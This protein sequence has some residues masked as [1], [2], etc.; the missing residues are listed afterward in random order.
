ME[1]IF[2]TGSETTQ[3]N[4]IMKS[5][6]YIAME[7]GASAKG[8]SSNIIP[9]A[10]NEFFSVRVR[11]MV[12]PIHITSLRIRIVVSPASGLMYAVYA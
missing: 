4:G 6:F 12:A 11:S 7:I 8:L 1:I 5:W 3:N 10:R 9:Y 2:I